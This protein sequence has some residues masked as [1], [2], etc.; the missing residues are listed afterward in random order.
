MYGQKNK[1]QLVWQ[2]TFDNWQI[3]GIVLADTLSRRGSSL[4]T[5]E[6][7]PFLP[8]GEKKCRSICNTW[9]RAGIDQKWRS[10]TKCSI[11]RSIITSP[12]DKI[13]S[14]LLSLD[15]LRLS[16]TM[17][18]LTGHIRLN[19]YLKRIQ[20]RDDPDCDCCGRSE[21]TSLHFLCNCPGLSHIR[22]SVFGLNMLTSNE[23]ESFHLSKIFKFFQKS[24]RFPSLRSNSADN[25]QI[26]RQTSRGNVQNALSPARNVIN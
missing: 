4:K 19:A 7:E 20:V 6:P 15:K 11:T 14:Q 8:L 25:T 3:V 26:T 1:T 16:Y 21:E 12:S 24:N 9:L 10:T 22:R 5:Y 18:I 23:V 2:M 17:G 13:A